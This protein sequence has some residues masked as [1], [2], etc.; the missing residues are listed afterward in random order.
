MSSE[1]GLPGALNF[2]EAITLTC[3]QSMSVV[4]D[5]SEG[6]GDNQTPKLSNY[7]LIL[8]DD[9]IT[10]TKIVKDENNPNGSSSGTELQQEGYKEIEVFDRYFHIKRCDEVLDEKRNFVEA[11]KDH[12][13]EVEV[14][15]NEQ[16][17]KKK[18]PK[19]AKEKLTIKC[20][21]LKNPKIFSF[22]AKTFP[23]FGVYGYVNFIEDEGL[24][25]EIRTGILLDTIKDINKEEEDAS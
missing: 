5:R 25:G 14:V 19:D 23:H 20:T 7:G 6:K 11:F 4:I 1:S 10:K 8:Q 21:K 16:T 3:G 15:E 2:S 24:N 22:T 17:I 12:V 13:E 18:F 9:T